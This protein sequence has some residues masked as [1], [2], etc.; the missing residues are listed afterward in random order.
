MRLEKHSAEWKAPAGFSFRHFSVPLYGMGAKQKKRRA[1]KD[2]SRML[3]CHMDMDCSVVL[4]YFHHDII[5]LGDCSKTKRPQSSE[6]QLAA[7]AHHAM[8][9]GMS[10]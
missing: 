1:Y 2:C 10:E 8:A 4:D 3:Q 7:D 6:V 9:S 5:A